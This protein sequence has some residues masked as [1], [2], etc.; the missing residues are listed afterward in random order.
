[1]LQVLRAEDMAREAKE[2]LASIVEV[3]EVAYRGRYG[4][5]DISQSGRWFF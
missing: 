4:V 5:L 2:V 3:F 1:M